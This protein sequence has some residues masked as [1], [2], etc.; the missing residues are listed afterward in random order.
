MVRPKSSGKRAESR[1]ELSDRYMRDLSE[2]VDQ[3]EIGPLAAQ[4][5]RDDLFE[6][7]QDGQGWLLKISVWRSY[8][9]ERTG[10]V[11]PYLVRQDGY[12]GDPAD[13]QTRRDDG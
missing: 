12:T 5:I 10:R 4:R 7:T 8:L 11:G 9:K 1:S 2:M 6:A 13:T 3:G